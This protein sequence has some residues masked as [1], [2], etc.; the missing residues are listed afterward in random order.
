VTLALILAAWCA[1]SVLFCRWAISNDE[2]RRFIERPRNVGC[3]SATALVIAFGLLVLPR[4]IYRLI[5][6]R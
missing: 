5:F 2:R 1:A 6:G 4:G 3:L